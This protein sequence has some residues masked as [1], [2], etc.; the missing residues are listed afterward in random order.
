MSTFGLDRLLRSRRGNVSILYALVAPIL[1]FAGGAAIDYGRAAQ[2]HTKLNA[3]AD[4]AALAALTPSMLGQSTSVAHDAAVNMFT[5][6]ADGITSLT[7]GA[8]QVTVTVTVDTT[9]LTRTV[10]VSYST[11]VNT[12]F[13]QVLGRPTLSLSGVSKASAEAPPNIDFYVL[14]D[15]SPSMALPATAAGITQ[16][17][18][19]TSKETLMTDAGSGGCAFACHQASTNNSDSAGNPCTD[20]TSPTQSGTSPSGKTVTNAYCTSRHGAQIDNY[21]LARKNNITL[22]LD[23]LNSGV[24]TLVQ[25]ASTSASSTVFATPPKY[26]FA[27]YSMDSLWQ[28]GLNQLMSLT[29]SYTSGW[30]SAS[31]NFGVMEMYSN[32]NDC[33]NSACSSGTS[34]PGGDV[35]TNYDDSLGKLSTTSYIPNPGNGT[36]QPGDT[37]QEVLFIVTDGVE[38]EQSGSQRLEQTMNDLAGDPNGRPYGN[39]PGTNWCSDIKNRGIKIAILY[40]DYLQVTANA[41]YV[42]HIEPFQPDIG[43]ALQACATPGLF[44]DEANDTN[45]GAD[46][47]KL[48]NLAAV[49]GHLT[50]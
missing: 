9:S 34:T 16:M 22:R 44:I 1:V 48:F 5:G 35:A 11:S 12:I 49:P 47:A 18:N 13:A 2:V 19:L 33:A 25:T 45:I 21:A 46:L 36:N 50:Q 43:S 15:N 37:P 7:P 10:E 29:S 30:T 28:I 14:L 3:A 41:W 26:R 23:E 38:D 4:A 40:T 8:T 24:S 42:S 39:A 32:N 20:G 6:L 31:A 17:Q 27:I